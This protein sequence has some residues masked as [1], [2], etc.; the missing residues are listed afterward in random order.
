MGGG[1]QPPLA[2][3]VKKTA[4]PFEL[5][6][7]TAILEEQFKAIGGLITVTSN[8]QFVLPPQ[9]SLAVQFTMVVPMGNVLPLGG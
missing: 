7:V 5:I 9:P 2:V 1:L 4:A 8:E 3:R 6:A